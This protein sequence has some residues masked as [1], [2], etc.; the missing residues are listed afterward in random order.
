MSFATILQL[1]KTKAQQGQITMPQFVKI[2]D[3]PEQQHKTDSTKDQC[4]KTSAQIGESVKQSELN[5]K[6]FNA[7]F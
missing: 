5:K 4:S 6:N 3:N 7:N 2:V 1:V